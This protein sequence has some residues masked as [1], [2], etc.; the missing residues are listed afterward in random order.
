MSRTIRKYE[1]E[2]PLKARLDERGH[3]VVS[4]VP[5]QPPLGYKK[6]PSVTD[7]IRDMVRSEMLRKEVEA[8]G[9]ETMEEADDFDIPDDPIDPST[10]FEENFDP[11]PPPP[12]KLTEEEWEERERKR[13][14][15]DEYKKL[16]AT[17][18]PA[19]QEVSAVKPDKSDV[20]AK[21]LDAPSTEVK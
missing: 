14:T 4:N 13:Y 6:E 1:E 7:R 16:R 20:P 15:E 9:L 10:P 8:A 3:E 18:P 2:V 12:L 19:G 17:K 11:P 5:M 21:P